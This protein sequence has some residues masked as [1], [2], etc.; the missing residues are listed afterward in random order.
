MAVMLGIGREHERRAPW[1]GIPTP[2][3]GTI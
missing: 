2:S 3:V 1:T